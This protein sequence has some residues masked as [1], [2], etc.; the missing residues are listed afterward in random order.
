M[1]KEE[2]TKETIE[3]VKAFSLRQPGNPYKSPE[4]TEGRYT[5]QWISWNEGWLLSRDTGEEKAFG[6][7]REAFK[8]GVS[9]KA[10]PYGKSDNII[11]LNNGGLDFRPRFSWVKGWLKEK[12][13]NVERFREI[14]KQD[15]NNTIVYIEE[16]GKNYREIYQV[17]QLINIFKY[18]F[19]YF[20]ARR[21]RK[22][23]VYQLIHSKQTAILKLA[24]YNIYSGTKEWRTWDALDGDLDA[25]EARS[26][27]Y[28]SQ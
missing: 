27:H 15:I 20:G 7:G 19:R 11:D 16:L 9:D 10:N 26:W 24:H 4:E 13:I 22:S 12:R 8:K 14:N 28:L 21:L 25:V 1:S 3:G 2:L 6:E 17:S 5:M 23:L 18:K